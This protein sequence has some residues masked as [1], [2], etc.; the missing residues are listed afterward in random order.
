[1]NLIA[2]LP[3]RMTCLTCFTPNSFEQRTSKRGGA[4]F[5]CPLCALR[6]FVN[7][8]SH[9]FGLLFWAKALSDPDTVRAA[10]A[11]LERALSQRG[12]EIPRASVPQEPVQACGGPIVSLVSQEVHR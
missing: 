4:Y 8:D 2:Q 12:A 10:R 1:V 5:V 7:N 3:Q 6:I 9:V 11:D